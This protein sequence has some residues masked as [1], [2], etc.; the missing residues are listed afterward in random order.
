MNTLVHWH[1]WTFNLFQFFDQGA[2]EGP[3]V[4][5]LD[6]L[7]AILRLFTYLFLQLT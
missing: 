2:R 7:N 4:T 6:S 5:T 3:C 1:D